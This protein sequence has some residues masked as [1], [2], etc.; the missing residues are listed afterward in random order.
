M[1]IRIVLLFISIFFVGKISA[2]QV[3]PAFRELMGEWRLTKVSMKLY[4][5]YGGAPMEEKIIGTL[6]SIRTINGFIPLSMQFREE[7]CIVEFR[8][9]IEM[10]RYTVSSPHQLVYQRREGL[11]P[12]STKRITAGPLWQYD[13]QSNTLLSIRMPE[14]YFVDRK[15]KLPVKLAY[16]CYYEKKK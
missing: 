3:S 6:D 1:Y 10:G 5:Q 11:R 4:S 12:D 7:D 14:S 8:G 2:Q 13:V 16:T 15:T 9:G